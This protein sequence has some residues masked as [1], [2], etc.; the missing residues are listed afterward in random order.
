MQSLVTLSQLRYLVRGCVISSLPY[1]TLVGVMKFQVEMGLIVLLVVVVLTVS[2]VVL[3]LIL[4]LVTMAEFRIRMNL[5]H[6]WLFL[7][8]Q[9][10]K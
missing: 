6:C 3:Q 1:P 7:I 4:L 8:R 10:V 9:G 2:M 5:T